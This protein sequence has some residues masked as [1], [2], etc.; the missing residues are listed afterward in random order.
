MAV[1]QSIMADGKTVLQVGGSG[2]DTITGDVI[3][4]GTP[5]TDDEIRGGRGADSLN[6]RSG[7]NDLFGQRGNDFLLLGASGNTF[8]RGFGGKGNDTFSLVMPPGNSAKM[9]LVSGGPGK[10]TVFLGTISSGNGVRLENDKVK[11]NGMKVAKL[12]AVE[13][14]NGSAQN[15][16]LK[17]S[18]DI[19]HLRGFAGDDRLDAHRINGKSILEGGDGNDTL[20]GAGGAQNLIDGSNPDDDATPSFFKDNDILRGKGGTDTLF[21]YSGD[22]LLKG[23][24][25]VDELYSIFGTDTLDGGDGNDE[26]LF[27]YLKFEQ[28]GEHTIYA[29]PQSQLAGLQIDGGKGKDYVRFIDLQVGPSFG[30]VAPDKGVRVDLALGQGKELGTLAKDSFRIKNVEKVVATDRDD[31]ILGNTAENLLKGLE[32]DD[33]LNGRNRS[34]TVEGHRGN[35][36]LLGG[37]GADE[38][39]GGPGNDLLTGGPGVDF[40]HFKK[41]DGKDTITDFEDRIDRINFPN[42]SISFDDLTIT[43]TAGGTLVKI[44]GGGSIFLQN[45]AAAQITIDDFLSI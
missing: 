1:T 40:F 26:L 25:G 20:N 4:G 39:S 18:G 45:I 24:S 36:T 29:R 14:V 30:D 21:S 12:L 10:D 22:D 41:V 38:I 42:K 44:D 6:G 8:D 34:D 17:S 15:D 16:F 13:V 35:D 23:G 37:K 7:Q 28:G 32:G 19:K 31:I 43:D 3:I 5:Y 33:K 9:H 11:L 2:N 27:S